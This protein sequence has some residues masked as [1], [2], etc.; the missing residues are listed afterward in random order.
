MTTQTLDNI[1]YDTHPTTGIKRTKYHI[2]K[3]YKNTSSFVFMN[4]NNNKQFHSHITNILLDNFVLEDLDGHKGKVYLDLKDQIHFEKIIYNNDLLIKLIDTILVKKNFSNIDNIVISIDIDNQ[5]ILDK[6]NSSKKEKD[7]IKLRAEYI[8]QLCKIYKYL[9]GFTNGS[10]L[11]LVEIDLGGTKIDVEKYL[12]L[13]LEF[14]RFLKNKFDKVSSKY[15]QSADFH[16]ISSVCDLCV[17]VN[18]HR[19]GSYLSY[20]DRS[21]KLTNQIISKIF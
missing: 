1:F 9:F 18:T 3:S 20:D 14:D 5:I 21:L 13:S 10:P 4:Q 2:V 8:K 16:F 7:K 12:K 11:D 15:L 19:H 6:I 17:T